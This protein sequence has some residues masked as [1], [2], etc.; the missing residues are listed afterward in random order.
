MYCALQ[1]LSNESDVEQKLLWPLLT[2]TFPAGLGLT[3][4]DVLTKPN[5]KRLTIGKGTSSKI[6]YPDYIVVIAGLPVL[7]IEA[8]APRQDLESAL[9]EARLYGNELNAFYSTG[10]NPCVRV[11]VCNGLELWSSP[12]DSAE[13]DSRLKHGELTSAHTRFAAFVDMVSRTVLQAHADG[14]RKQLRH[15]V[16]T[17]PLSTVGGQTV[18]NQE[19]WDFHFRRPRMDP[20]HTRKPQRPRESFS[21]HNRPGSEAVTQPALTSWG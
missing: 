14:L 9:T 20:L 19:L 5:I 6:Y 16:Y 4:A 18:Q 1:D 3:P 21:S 17:R 8:K 7:V 12:I 10:I 15:R 2:T 13:A 11:V